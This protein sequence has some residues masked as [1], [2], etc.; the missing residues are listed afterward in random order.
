MCPD[1]TCAADAA[2]TNVVTVDVN[3]PL[4]SVL[5]TNTKGADRRSSIPRPRVPLEAIY[6]LILWVQHGLPPP[7]M[8]PVWA[9][10]GH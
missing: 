1:I 5:E 3:A 8:R 7:N 6:I 2:T 10:K 9:K 4:R